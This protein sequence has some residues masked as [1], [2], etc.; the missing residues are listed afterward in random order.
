MPKTTKHT[1][2][3][4]EILDSMIVADRTCVVSY[5]NRFRDMSEQRKAN[6]RLITAAP[7][8]LDCLSYLAH[9]VK[10]NDQANI[11]HGLERAQATIAKATVA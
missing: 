10:V 1:Q 11:S 3:P 9:S 2:G 5:H 7:E 6:A 4:W 8:L